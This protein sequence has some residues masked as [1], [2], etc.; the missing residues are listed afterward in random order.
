VTGFAA[1]PLPLARIGLIAA[2]VVLYWLV[3]PGRRPAYLALVSAAFVAAVSR[4]AAL[5]VVLDVVLV[6]VCARN[7][8]AGPPRHRRLVLGAGL[9]WLIG[10][11][12]LLKYGPLLFGAPAVAE[13]TGTTA[14]LL[15]LGYSFVVFRSI[16]VLVEVYRGRIA[17]A[18]F[19]DLASYL[20][21]FP[22]YLAGPVER[23]PRFVQQMRTHLRCDGADVRAGLLRILLG[24]FKKI[25]LAELLSM[26]VRQILGEPRAHSGLDVLLAVY[27]AALW[28]YMDFAGYTDIALGLGRL[29]GLRLVENFHRP[30]LATNIAVFWRSWHISLYSFIRDYFFLPLFGTRPTRFKTACGVICTMLVFMLWHGA[31]PRWLVLGL[32][33]GT[34]LVGWSLLQDAKLHRPRLRRAL[35]SK[36]GTLASWLLTV[37]FVAFG[38]LLFFYDVAQVGAIVG[39]LVG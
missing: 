16:H 14:I 36:A 3:S 6:F 29:C 32:Y 33:H 26:H 22:T 17:D 8:A 1:A 30:F 18:G 12:C 9:T 5:A 38:F 25:V 31:E 15:P 13:S 28:L 35:A 10:S 20:L 34:A 27:G 24:A 21:F 39:R 4:V 37:H 2:S 7:M 11:L 19:W 23:F